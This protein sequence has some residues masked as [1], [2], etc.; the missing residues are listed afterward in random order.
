MEVEY[1][2]D[3]TVSLRASD[4]FLGA[5]LAGFVYANRIECL[6]WEPL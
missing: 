5:D 4:L 6:Q 1:Y 3:D 2:S